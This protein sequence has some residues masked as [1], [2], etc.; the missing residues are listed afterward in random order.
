MERLLEVMA[1]LRDPEGGCPWDIEQ[2]FASIRPYTIEESYEVAD[3][4]DRGDMAA[5][6]EE[7]G[8]LLLQ[9]V[10]HAQMA[11]EA[12]LFDF[13][14]VAE[15]IADKMVAR[16]PHVFG[17][18][19]VASAAGQTRAWEAH[20]SAEREAKAAAAGV[21]PSVLDDVALALPALMRA[22]KLQKRAAR[23][24]FDWPETDGTIVKVE[25]EIAELRRALAA[26]RP[27]EVADEVGDLLFSVV[28][29]A[30]RV[31]ADAEDALRASNAKF[32]RRFRAMERTAAAERVPLAERDLDALERLWIAA[33]A[34]EAEP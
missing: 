30:R 15:S 1:R 13:E 28:N 32:E 10:Y 9:V 4:I 16:H 18:A 26:G 27:E 12:G 23:V 2:D 25:E 33:K 3:A 31:G 20:K 14:A 19:D 11:R 34:A 24:G 5:L 7:L 6:K 8:D 22:E 21:T 29:L 17:D